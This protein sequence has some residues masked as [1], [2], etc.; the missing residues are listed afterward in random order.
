MYISTF[1]QLK[2]VNLVY[3]FTR[4]RKKTPPNWPNKVTHA[5]IHPIQ[6]QRCRISNNVCAL[7]RRPRRH[8][9]LVSPTMEFFKRSSWLRLWN[10]FFFPLPVERSLRPF[11]HHHHH[12]VESV[13]KCVCVR[14]QFFLFL[15]PVPPMH[16]LLYTPPPAAAAAV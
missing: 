1:V 11:G 12:H 14:I 6:L 4:C 5:L 8:F 10:L 9:E 16:V 13:S 2:S 15:T 3:R 7:P